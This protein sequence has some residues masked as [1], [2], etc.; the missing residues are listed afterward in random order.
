MITFR[1][2]SPADILAFA[3]DMRPEEMASIIAVGDQPHDAVD[4]SLRMS[5]WSHMVFVDD[6]PAVVWGIIPMGGILAAWGM[7]WCMTTPV[8]LG[9]KK[10]FMRESWR[11]LD[12]CHTIYPRLETFVDARYDRS[13]AWLLRLGF[14]MYG[15]YDLQGMSVLT[16]VR[17]K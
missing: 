4:R 15:P 11:F 9:H 1:E 8:M 2:P 5:L 12:F 13:R 17:E 3:A 14:V 6:A 10:R 16:A 7:P